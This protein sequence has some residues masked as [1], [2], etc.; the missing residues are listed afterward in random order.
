MASKIQR[1][2]SLRS[3]RRLPFWL[4][5]CAMLLCEALACWCKKANPVN[6]AVQKSPATI[7]SAITKTDEQP[8]EQLQFFLAQIKSGNDIS[9]REELIDAFLNN[10]NSN[11]ISNV[12]VMLQ[13][14]EPGD[15]AKDLR[16]RVIYQWAQLEPSTVAVQADNWDAET[17]RL[18]M[19]DVA[20]AWANLQLDDAIAWS[21][22]LPDEGDRDRAISLIANEAVR[23]DPTVALQL[24]MSLPINVERNQ[25][26]CRAVT[27]WALTDE[28]NAQTWSEQISNDILREQAVAAVATVLG[29]SNPAAAADL[30]VQELPPGKAQQDAIALIIQHWAQQ[31]P[32]AAENWVEQTPQGFLREVAEQNLFVQQAISE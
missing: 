22:G 20:I 30:A 24:A 12:L 29:N 3:S 13:T 4:F 2:G 11:E 8:L 9:K 21:K 26:V 15:L 10:L 27:E 28:P 18:A 25:L 14:I 32:T 7:P 16:G 17:R 1:D 19:D 6:P 5:I 31:N 23:I